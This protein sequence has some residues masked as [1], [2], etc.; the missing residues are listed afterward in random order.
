MLV[1]R[2][3]SDDDSGIVIL[4]CQMKMYFDP[5]LELYWRD[6]SN[7]GSQYIVCVFIDK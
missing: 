4:I 7:E 6:S 5:T 1:I 2:G 3:L